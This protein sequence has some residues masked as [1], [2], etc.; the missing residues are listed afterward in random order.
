MKGG[1][2]LSSVTYGL[3][4]A[5]TDDADFLPR[6][7]IIKSVVVCVGGWARWCEGCWCHN[8]ILIGLETFDQRKRALMDAGVHRGIC[9]WG[10]KRGTELALGKKDE[11][12]AS[13][14]AAGEDVIWS[15]S[16]TSD[17]FLATCAS[18]RQ[19][20]CD[21]VAGELSV[22]LDAMWNNIPWIILG[23]YGEEQGF[24]SVVVNQF[25]QQVM[26]G[27]AALADKRNVHAVATKYLDPSGR[28]HASLSL[29]LRTNVPLLRLR[30]TFLAIRGHAAALLVSR[31]N[32]GDHRHLNMESRS[33]PNISAPLLMARTNFIQLEPF[34]AQSGF[35]TFGEKWWSKRG[36]HSI[37]NQ[38]LAHRFEQW[39]LNDM[40]FVQKASHVYG[41][42]IT[43][44]FH[45]APAASLVLAIQNKSSSRETPVQHEL[46]Q[47]FAKIFKPG[48]IFSFTRDVFTIDTD[49]IASV[50]D[51]V[52]ALSNLDPDAI[53]N[54]TAG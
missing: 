50:H 34:L 42:A 28:H 32:E 49:F 30:E 45:H 16:G 52:S 15:L 22:K 40:G 11:M 2:N 51:V 5:A 36:K 9:P 7:K 31:R 33:T 1:S 23:F 29:K 13:I 54:L 47:L 53:E 38:L 10:G 24:S 4:K 12:I 26:D 41:T 21:A 8:D 44:L 18:L 6:V 43:D 14:R 37:V 46:L 25:I 35:V 48:S 20:V 3:V 27:Y 19:V 17:D 39:R